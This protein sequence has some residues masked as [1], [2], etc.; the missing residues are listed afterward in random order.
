MFT[1]EIQIW[2]RLPT[3]D[4]TWIR[5]NTYFTL[6]HQDLRENTTMSNL[7][8]PANNATH[9]SELSEVMAYL[10]TATA[11]DRATVSTLTTTISRLTAELLITDALLVTA[12]AANTTITASMGR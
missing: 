2:K 8:G 5:L 9:D 3:V 11:A 6:V 7:G 4:K 10:A 1:D 12:L